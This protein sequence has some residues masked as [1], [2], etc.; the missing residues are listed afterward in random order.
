MT[1]RDTQA[2]PNLNVTYLFGP[3]TYYRYLPTY[4]LEK[5]GHILRIRP[6]TINISFSAPL[7]YIRNYT[8]YVV[9]WL[10]IDIV[11]TEFFVYRHCK[12]CIHRS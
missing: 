6:H 5:N 12:Y 1:L 7:L 4:V 2:L 3:G 9:V 10:S 11:C 8:K